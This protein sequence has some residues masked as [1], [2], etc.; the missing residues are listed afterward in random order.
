M[1]KSSDG[2]SVLADQTKWDSSASAASDGMVAEKH[3]FTCPEDTWQV[4]LWQTAFD[5]DIKC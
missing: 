1:I 2:A 4:A 5:G 3:Y